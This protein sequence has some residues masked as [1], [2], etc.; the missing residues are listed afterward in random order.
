MPLSATSSPQSL[1]GVNG[2]RNHFGMRG[3]VATAN[4]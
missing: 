1:F 4:E 2:E 3:N